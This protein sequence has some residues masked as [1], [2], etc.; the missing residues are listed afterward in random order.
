MCETRCKYGRGAELRPKMDVHAVKWS[1]AMPIE[2]E[3]IMP[4]IVL[5]LLGLAMG[6]SFATSF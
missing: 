2:R 1:I 3:N 4:L 5:A 6:W